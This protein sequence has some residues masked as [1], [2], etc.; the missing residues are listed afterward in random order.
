MAVRQHQLV[1]GPTIQIRETPDDLIDRKPTAVVQFLETTSGLYA[2]KVWEIRFVVYG[3]FGCIGKYVVLV[4]CI[5]RGRRSRLALKHGEGAQKNCSQCQ[6]H[7]S[8]DYCRAWLD[9]LNCM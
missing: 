1:T 2:D 6:F 3:I 5:G 7:I 4:T 9:S 8:S